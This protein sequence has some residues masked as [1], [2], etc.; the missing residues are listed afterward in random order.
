MSSMFKMFTSSHRRL[1]DYIQRTVCHL[2]KS[3]NKTI[4]KWINRFH[5]CLADDI[6]WTVRHS[7]QSLNHYFFCCL[8][9]GNTS[10][11]PASASGASTWSHSMAHCPFITW[12]KD[13]RILKWKA[14]V[15]IFLLK[16]REIFQNIKFLEVLDILAFLLEQ[17]SSCSPTLCATWPLC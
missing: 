16:W 6:K 17:T 11:S 14:G 5:C 10:N 2:N 4:H 8:T 7:S 12:R 9:I 1:T 3:I 15:S 13:S